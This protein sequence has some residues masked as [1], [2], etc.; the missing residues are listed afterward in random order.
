MTSRR[1]GP[2]PPRRRLRRPPPGHSPRPAPP[3]PP[4]PPRC[5]AAGLRPP[6]SPRPPGGWG[7]DRAPLPR[8]PSSPRRRGSSRS[9]SRG[10]WPRR[11][12]PSSSRPCRSWRGRSRT[13]WS[14]SRSCRRRRAEWVSGAGAR[15]T[16]PLGAA[17]VKRRR[18][19]LGG[20]HPR[21]PPH[22]LRQSRRVAARRSPC[23]A[24]SAPV[25]ASAPAASGLAD[26][27]RTEVAAEWAAR[28][29]PGRERWRGVP[30]H[31][32]RSRFGTSLVLQCR[33]SSRMPGAPPEPCRQPAPR[34]WG[35]WGEDLGAFGGYSGPAGSPGPPFRRGVPKM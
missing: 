17:G 27:Q 7:G 10:S 32:G 33:A 4:P 29:A 16:Q 9:C 25:P 21:L 19:P 13:W 3:A 8:P 14:S 35:G 18:Q 28:A 26:S 23:R 24:G 20:R 2:P 1:P 15:G 22:R 5:D 12:P 30:H 11:R 31:A 34:L 6:P